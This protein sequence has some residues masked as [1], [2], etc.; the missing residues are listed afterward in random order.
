MHSPQKTS[1]Q[2]RSTEVFKEQLGFLKALSADEG[3]LKKPR[4]AQH[5]PSL[6]ARYVHR[7]LPSM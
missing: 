7:Y 1:C 5:D 3:Q 2:L 6:G 4:R